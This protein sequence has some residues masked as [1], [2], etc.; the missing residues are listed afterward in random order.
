MSTLTHLR[1]FDELE[2]RR[3]N[4]RHKDATVPTRMFQDNSAAW[5][6]S[7]N[8]TQTW[9]NTCTYWG[10]AGQHLR[11]ALIGY[12]VG[13]SVTHPTNQC[14]CFSIREY[15]KPAWPNSLRHLCSTLYIDAGSC[16]SLRSSHDHLTKAKISTWLVRSVKVSK[17][18]KNV[19]LILIILF[20]RWTK[21]RQMYFSPAKANFN[22][23]HIPI[24]H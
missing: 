12:G 8:A 9:R 3:S 17:A 22:C 5:T 15:G 23:I 24:L 16:G 18:T 6:T 10:D 19:W 7:E 20:S 14:V 1:N 11:L 2:I 13:V 21:S 4:K